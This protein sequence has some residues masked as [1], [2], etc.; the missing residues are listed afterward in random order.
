MLGCNR[1]EKQAGTYQQEVYQINKQ[2]LNKEAKLQS[3][4]AR[5]MEMQMNDSGL[6]INDTTDLYLQAEIEAMHNQHEELLSSIYSAKDSIQSM[7]KLDKYPV[8]KNASN[9]FLTAYEKIATNEYD[10]LIQLISLH[11]TS[12]TKE[13]NKAYLITRRQLNAGLDKAINNF[14]SSLDQFESKHFNKP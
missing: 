13:K 11:D 14:N 5:V 9:E 2:V 4:I 6:L 8:L 1:S 10:M 3:Q 12:Y 7:Q